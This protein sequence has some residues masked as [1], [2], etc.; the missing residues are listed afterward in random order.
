MAPQ[1][2]R[3]LAR[4]RASARGQGARGVRRPE[5]VFAK[6]ACRLHPH[7]RP[8]HRHRRDCRRLLL[9]LSRTSRHNQGQQQSL[10]A[11]VS[12]CAGTRDS[13]GQPRT[14]GHS[15]LSHISNVTMETIETDLKLFALSKPISDYLYQHRFRNH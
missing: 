12:A 6:A 4:A 14:P 2:L 13:R 5:E 10:N 7:S 9:L 11:T 15:V 1:T 8:Y 3:R